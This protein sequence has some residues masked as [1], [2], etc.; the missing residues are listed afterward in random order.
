[1]RSWVLAAGA[2]ALSAMPTVLAFFS[3]GFFDKP[4]IV[5]ALVAWALV[6]LAAIFGPRPLPASGPARAA[7]LGLLLLCVW[8]ALSLS[9]APLGGRAQDDLQ[10]VVL[11]L[12]FFTAALALLR[13]EPV[14][15]AL[16]P[17]LALG[18]FIVVAYAL[19]ERL[20]PGIVELDSSAT[21]AGRL[22]QPL[23]YWNAVGLAAAIGLVLAIRVAGD[24][25]RGRALRATLAA[26]GVPL[27]LGVYLT[28]SRGA[29]AA[30]A[31]GLLVLVALAP[32][33]RALVRSVL[34][35]VGA[36]A[37]AALLASNLTTVKS[38][39]ERDSGE[40]L[41]ML[42]A[43]ALL[44]LAAALVAPREPS[45][46]P[47][48]RSVPVPRPA[49]VAGVLALV[50]VVG[51]LVLVAYEG[52][53]ESASP[54]TGADPARLGSIDTNRYRYWEVAGTTFADHPIAGAGSGAFLV[55]WLKVDD[56]VD[57]AAD[58]HSLYIETAA[59]LGMVGLACLVLFLGGVAAGGVRLH[60]LAPGAAAGPLAALAAW[61]FHAALDWDWEMPAVTLTA[62]L[63]AAAALAWSEEPASF[64]GSR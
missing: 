5:A 24:P 17:A 53:P 11:Y 7:L 59:E 63:L 12:G 51:G 55:E 54:V 29:L 25:A 35:V 32:S 45:R 14:Q 57:A 21:A 23:T 56:R 61:A 43:L 47:L 8:T 44:G 39:A 46:P 42:V 27:G 4:R 28:F 19:S 30:L 9:W 15:R 13:G 34:V 37:L 31:V 60:R 50:M 20:L 38:L 64:G 41:T 58:A 26:A 33:S 3:G 22:E 1:M 40:G 62:L 18:A 16:E 49:V 2:T 10:R 36:S 48:F 52:R 6:A